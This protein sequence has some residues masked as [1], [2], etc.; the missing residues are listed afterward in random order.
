LTA[1]AIPPLA[2]RLQP[3]QQLGLKWLKT[4]LDYTY[5]F[6]RGSRL[7]PLLAGAALRG[8]DS[9]DIMDLT[10]QWLHTLY[11]PGWWLNQGDA[12]YLAAY[13]ADNSDFTAAI[14]KYSLG[15]GKLLWETPLD[16]NERREGWAVDSRGVALA[17]TNTLYY[18]DA[19]SGQLGWTKTTSKCSGPEMYFAEQDLHVWCQG[20]LSRIDRA[21]GAIQA[22]VTVSQNSSYDGAQFVNGKIFDLR[23]DWNDQYRYGLVEQRFLEARN[24]ETYAILWSQPLT[25][26][27]TCQHAPLQE[28]VIDACGSQLARFNG[29]TGQP[30]WQ[31]T[32]DS[33][34]VLSSTTTGPWAFYQ[35]D[36]IY[37]FG[38][39]VTRFNGATGLAIWHIVLRSDALV[40]LTVSGHR[41]VVGTTT[42]YLHILNADTGQLTWE[43]DVW[44]SAE[45]RN[46]YMR[47]IGLTDQTLII[48]AQD[49]LLALGLDGATSWPVPTS[50]PAVFPTST[51]TSTPT[52]YPVFTPPPA[53]VMPAPPADLQAWPAAI[54]AFLNAAPG[55][56]ARLPALLE[57]WRKS[58]QDLKT[59]LRMADLDGDGQTAWII[60]LASGYSEGWLSVIRQNQQGYEVAWLD[61]SGL[62]GLDLAIGSSSN[63]GDFV[64]GDLNADGHNDLVYTMTWVGV[65]TLSMRVIPL[66]WNGMAFVSLDPAGLISLNDMTDLKVVAQPNSGQKQIIITGGVSGCSYG[67]TQQ[68]EKTITYSL[69]D[70]VYAL[71]TTV[72][73]L[74]RQYYFYLLD[75][76]QKLLDGDNAGVITLLKDS[77]TS[78]APTERTE[79][80]MAFAEYELM[81]ANVRLGNDQ[82][83][84]QW[85]ESAHYPAELYSQ[86]KIAF[87]HGY[88][89]NHDWTMAAEVARLRARL[90]GP[91]RMQ[92]W[93]IDGFGFP[94][95]ITLEQI[96][97][98][99]ECVQGPLARWSMFGN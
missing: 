39:Q 57:S 99:P 24:A 62:P 76:N 86:I 51:A 40:S 25:T 68:Y 92:P 38:N 50:E 66:S 49:Q 1:T 34:E 55:N 72:P 41:L 78:A 54:A 9:L 13:A 69:H 85:A 61:T 79:T 90:A 7:E 65:C 10:G 28:D 95:Y 80:E 43:Q 53:N 84:A 60:T 81:L 45:P 94:G 22:S 83:A 4:N 63:S 71:D 6:D 18:L 36:V 30:I 3:G 21:T 96:I 91:E 48:A 59:S 31:T 75:A 74:H 73:S 37:A 58:G 88:Q 5:Y 64:I 33:G 46:V 97:P 29:T 35:G 16:S 32:A 15:S 52:P 89:K 47:P 56:S 26:T 14:R 87:W 11:L 20:Y 67:L 98:C 77:L 2:Q 8:L 17:S 23:T 27:G 19:D 44:A 42:G 82:A 70:G 12:L 93:P